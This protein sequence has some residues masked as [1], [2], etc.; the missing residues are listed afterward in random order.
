MKIYKN[1]PQLNDSSFLE[2]GE[3]IIERKP[4]YKY[5]IKIVHDHLNDKIQLKSK[6]PDKLTSSSKFVDYNRPH[7]KFL[8]DKNEPFTK[9]DIF[10]NS[11]DDDF[12][13]K[14]CNCK[15]EIYNIIKESLNKIENE[16]NI[17]NYNRFNQPNKLKYFKN[18]LKIE[19]QF[20]QYIHPSSTRIKYHISEMNLNNYTDVKNNNI[21]YITSHKNKKNKLNH[22]NKKLFYTPDKRIISNNNKNINNSL[23]SS[24]DS[25]NIIKNK[26]NISLGLLNNKGR[27]YK[28][29]DLMIHKS[30]ESR[31]IIKSIPAGKKINPLILKKIVF[32]PVLDTV[33]IGSCPT[34]K[35]LKQ[36]SVL[37]SIER[38]PLYLKNSNLSNTR[39]KKFIKE[40][41]TNV[42]TT[43]TKNINEEKNNNILN[44]SFD[45]IK[46]NKNKK[47]LL[48]KKSI[49][50]KSI[51]KKNYIHYS[52]QIR[53]NKN[54][55]L[56]YLLDNNDNYINNYS[57]ITSNLFE[58]IEPNNTIR[59]KEE[60]K[61]L[62]Y[63]YYRF[64]NLNSKNDN[65]LES[66]KNYFLNLSDEEK[67][68]ILTHLKNNGE[69]DDKIYKKLV[70]LLEEKGTKEK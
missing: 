60:V 52:N 11:Y 34:K 22:K 38:K 10:E 49:N 26:N 16:E 62:K 19:K 8:E 37:T 12:K 28:N 1:F 5:E 18:P 67:I 31:E 25:E 59:I 32:K 46:T 58:Q 7:N 66:L 15:S 54:S 70:N 57:S 6:T 69:E 39:Q 50:N 61:Y 42:Y 47:N 43:L 33:Q 35:V 3:Y 63:L 24:Y 14:K 68:G 30:S 55:N 64:S 51:R 53:N 2:E 44:K 20:Q 40:K 17:N 27:N 9:I 29:K 36:T 45:Y 4:K 13:H 21:I 56:N 48:N 23:I 41:I 65:K